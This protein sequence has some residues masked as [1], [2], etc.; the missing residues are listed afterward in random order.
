MATTSLLNSYSRFLNNSVEEFLTQDLNLPIETHVLKLVQHTVSQV[1]AYQDFLTSHGVLTNSITTPEDFTRLPLMT[2]DNYIRA[3]PLSTRCRHGNLSNAEMFA[4]SSGSTGQ[5]TVWPRNLHDELVVAREF[6]RVLKWN[7]SSHE[8]STLAVIC[9]ALGTWVGGLYTTAICRHLAQ[10]G[11]PISVVAPGNNVTEILRVVPELGQHFEQVILFGYPPFIKTVLDAGLASGLCWADFNVKMVYAGEV[12]SE[13]WRT[14]VTG[15][16]TGTD[17]LRTTATLYGTA[18][19]GVLGA[20]TP[21]SIAIRR[22]LAEKPDMAVLLFGEAR[23]PTLVQYNPWSRYFEKNGETLVVTCDGTVPLIRYHI[24]DKGGI[25][26]FDD[27]M[28][29]LRRNGCEPT[30]E[31]AGPLSS[32][33]IALPF[34]YVFGRADFTVSYFGANIYPENIAVGLEQPEFENSI[35]GKFVLEVRET[36]GGDS[37]L[38]LAVELLPRVEPHAKLAA[39]LSESVRSQTI[40]I[41]SEFAHYVPAP[42]QFPK[43][44]LRPY[45]DA[46]WFPLGVKHRYTRKK[47]A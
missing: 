36:N 2:K 9:F 46:E 37:E 17:V 24:A 5:P 16:V 38:H 28:A 23:L 29:W 10:K 18:D 30:V 40:R 12:F 26:T 4:V 14:L 32:S 20:E 13:A 27:M 41:N 22:Y 8:R 31:F 1:P 44:T 35:T 39:A 25:I 19:A 34:V 6:E 45:G 7:F 43:V 42:N 47:N 33:A 21:L 3:F 11:F 15:R